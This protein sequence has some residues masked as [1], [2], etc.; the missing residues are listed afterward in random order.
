[1]KSQGDNKAREIQQSIA[2]ILLHEWHPIGIHGEPKARGE[3]DACVGGIN[4]LRASV[5]TP[6]AV[7]QHLVEIESR[8]RGSGNILA[9]A[10]YQLLRSSSL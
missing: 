10:R 6:L 7:A 3:Y 4:R 1:M 8:H 5:P 2:S 9:E